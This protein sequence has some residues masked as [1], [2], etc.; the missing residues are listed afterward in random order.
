M[1]HWLAADRAGNRLVITGD[2]QSWVLVARFDAQNGT[3][4]VDQTFREHGAKAPGFSFD[5]DEWPHG[6]TGRAIVHGALFGP[7]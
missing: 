5:R 2:G 7:H 6:K 4:S 3:L 1:P